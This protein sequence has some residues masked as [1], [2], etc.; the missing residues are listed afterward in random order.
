MSDPTKIRGFRNVSTSHQTV[1]ITEGG[2]AKIRQ[3]SP[4]RWEVLPRG[5][6]AYEVNGKQEA[7]ERARGVETG[8]T[9][10]HLRDLQEKQQRL[11]SSLAEAPKKKSSAQIKREINEVLAR[12]PQTVD[13][14]CVM[15]GECSCH[16]MHITERCECPACK[17]ALEPR[18]RTA[19]SHATIA[20]SRPWQGTDSNE[21]LINRV[22]NALVSIYLDGVVGI[23]PVIGE[24][25]WKQIQPEK[26]DTYLQKGNEVLDTLVSQKAPPSVK[27]WHSHK[28]RQLRD[29]I[30]KAQAVRDG[31]SHQKMTA[32]SY[33]ELRRFLRS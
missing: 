13:C 25:A 8:L 29:L 2:E 11:R 17:E 27:S 32:E 7:I 16:R 18:K 12:K 33:A 22:H 21:R 24:Y 14:P 15:A 5:G 31:I 20:K 26:A 23:S 19:A 4:R 28:V 6:E 1:F 30:E 9:P 10:S 3:I